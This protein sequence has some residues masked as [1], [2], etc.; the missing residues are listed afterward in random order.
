MKFII[1]I[2]LRIILAPVPGFIRNRIIRA[3]L[4]AYKEGRKN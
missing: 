3:I 4:G 2:F 1:W